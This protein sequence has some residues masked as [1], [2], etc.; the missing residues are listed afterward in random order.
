MRKH[1]ALHESKV[2]KPIMAPTHPIAAD[3]MK[4]LQKQKKILRAQNM[5]PARSWYQWARAR[6]IVENRN[7]GSWQASGEF[8]RKQV[9]FEHDSNWSPELAV[10]KTC[11]L[12]SVYIKVLSS[13]LKL[14]FWEML[15]VSD[16][17]ALAVKVSRNFT[18][19]CEILPVL[20]SRHKVRDYRYTIRALVLQTPKYVK[21]CKCG[22][23]EFCTAWSVCHAIGR[24][25]F[26]LLESPSIFEIAKT[27]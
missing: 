17:S 4:R 2:K 9:G 20:S 13:H 18:V 1:A 6:G 14:G 23:G 16:D 25:R 21:D 12:A 3:V 22:C 5:L 7:A 19:A 8:F 24:S 27:T 10:L 26:F 15:G 11:P